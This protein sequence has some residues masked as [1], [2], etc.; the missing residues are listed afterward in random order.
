MSKRSLVVEDQPD[1]RHLTDNVHQDRQAKLAAAQS[2]KTSQGA[3]WKAPSK[4][5]LKIGT[6]DSGLHA[7]PMYD[8]DWLPSQGARLFAATSLQPRE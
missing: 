7:L 2:Y 5:L 1:R 6:A 4:R 3:N 8:A